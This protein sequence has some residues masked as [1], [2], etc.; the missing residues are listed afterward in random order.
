[1][2]GCEMKLFFQLLQMR[3]SERKLHQG[4]HGSVHG[5][6]SALASLAT[7]RSEAAE[8]KELRSSERGE[9]C[10]ALPETASIPR[11]EGQAEGRVQ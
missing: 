5:S 6:L 1:M 11:S 2:S 8:T 4:A 10:E 9:S 7:M 3:F